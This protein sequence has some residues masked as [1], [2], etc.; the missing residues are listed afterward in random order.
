MT[1]H[2]AEA[3]QFPGVF[4]RQ[5]GGRAP[6]GLVVMGLLTIFMILALD[7]NS[8]ASRGTAV[9]L[10][11]LSTVTASHFKTYR[12][13]GA[14]VIVLVVALVATLGTFVIFTTTTLVNEPR[15]AIALVV[16]IA[17]AILLDFGWKGL[18]NHRDARP[19]TGD[20]AGSR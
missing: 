3:G 19:V 9:A 14:R 6:V 13:T 4:G 11:I 18:Q 10:L 12:E 16:V 8:I 1:R 5:I 15:T 17:A 20:Q 7:L 2:L